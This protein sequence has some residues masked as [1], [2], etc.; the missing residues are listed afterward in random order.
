MENMTEL[1]ISM[2]ETMFARRPNCEEIFNNWEKY[3]LTLSELKIPLEIEAL[4]K[5][6]LA[7]IATDSIYNEY[8][9]KG[10][11]K[12]EQIARRTSSNTMNHADFTM[13]KRIV[14]KNWDK[15]VFTFVIFVQ[16][17]ISVMKMFLS[18]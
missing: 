8:L 14:G 10:L 6:L 17:F 18:W 5:I 1:V 4:T 12:Q 7:K 11:P 2:T 15:Y 13:K 3:N 9:D 16:H